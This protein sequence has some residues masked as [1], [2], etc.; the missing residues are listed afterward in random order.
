[1]KPRGWEAAW[2]D[3]LEQ[4]D[5]ET[6]KRERERTG[7]RPYVA[8]AIEASAVFGSAEL[9]AL[10]RLRAKLPAGVERKAL[11][12]DAAARSEL[13]RAGAAFAFAAIGAGLRK[14]PRRPSARARR[15][16]ARRLR[17]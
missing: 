10:D 17:R 8:P 16:R 4:L 6:A 7:R 11:A 15:E 3:E 2:A 13:F 12:L 14:A 5:W 1:M 9:A